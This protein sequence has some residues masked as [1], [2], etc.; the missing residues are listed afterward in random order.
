MEAS[1]I[2][3]TYRGAKR[4]RTLLDALTQQDFDGSWEVVVSMDGEV[5]DTRAVVDDYA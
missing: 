5:D 4:I 2:V 3:P 1:V